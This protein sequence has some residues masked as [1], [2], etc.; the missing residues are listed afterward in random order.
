MTPPTILLREPKPADALMVAQSAQASLEELRPWMPWATQ[1]YGEADALA[2]INGEFGD[3]HRFLIMDPEGQHLGTVGLNNLDALNRCANLGYWVHSAHHSKGIATEATRQI[4]RYGLEK[5]AIVRF[6]VLMSVHNIA[7]Q[8][9]AEKAG[10][11]FE[12]IARSRVHLLGKTHD[13]RVYS[14]VR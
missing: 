7:S 10:A 3:A 4:L 14:F 9:V 6:E 12:G 8:R 13:A 2:W 1:D 5:T 11:V